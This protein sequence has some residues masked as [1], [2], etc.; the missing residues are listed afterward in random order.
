MNGAVA[1][2][3]SVL[4]LN[5]FFIAVHVVSARRAFALLCKNAAEVVHVF[6]NDRYDSFDFH[7]WREVSQYRELF[8]DGDAHDW[9]HTV[10]FEIRVPRVVRLLGYDRLPQQRVKFNRRN[11]FARDEN[12]CQY[13]GKRFPTTELSIDHVVPKSRGGPTT[14]GNVVC[15][16]T[17]CNKRKGGTSAREA[18]M[19]LIRRA[20]APKRCPVMRLKLKSE[21][22]RSWKAFLSHAYWSV[23]LR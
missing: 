11:L 6:G 15:A 5:R 17:S 1:L 20:V 21:K 19:I 22:Y 9:V 16:C 10:S 13:C 2:N 4:V 8:E 7:S 18:G 14:W 12:R 23:E 3:S